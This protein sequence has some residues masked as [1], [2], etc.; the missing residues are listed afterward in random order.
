MPASN[1]RLMKIWETL[2]WVEA[3]ERDGRLPLWPP[4]SHI[5]TASLC[6]VSVATVRKA[7]DTG[8]TENW[9]VPE[10][11]ELPPLGEA[12]EPVIVEG[13]PC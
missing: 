4:Q 5:A 11:D 6:G 10:L 3:D 7:Y 13:K 1:E 9:D 8:I 12:D 2:C